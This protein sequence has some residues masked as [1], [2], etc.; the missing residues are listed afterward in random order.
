M[1]FTFNDTDDE[2]ASKGVGESQLLPEGV[3][4]FSVKKVNDISISNNQNEQLPIDLIVE[5]MEMTVFLTL[6]E[7]AKWR[8]SRFLKSLKKGE[9][10]S[11]INFNPAK[12][13]WLEGKT[14]FAYVTHRLV[15]Q[16]K[17]K[18][19]TFNDIKDFTWIGDVNYEGKFP[20]NSAGTEEQHSVEEDDIP[21]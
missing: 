13:S 7:R 17:Y 5:G 19:K 9:S 20:D 16:G 1:N 11:G 15:D 8:L 6:T 3:Y 18:G 14:G 21:F 4:P 10:I 12:C 2:Q